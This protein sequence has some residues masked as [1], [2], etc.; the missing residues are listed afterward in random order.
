MTLRSRDRPQSHWTNDLLAKILSK[1]GK[2]HEAV[3]FSAR[4]CERFSNQES[5]ALHSL[6]LLKSGNETEALSLA[7][8]AASMHE[9]SF[10]VSNLAAYWTLVGEPAKAL[11]L[12]RQAVELGLTD[13]SLQNNPDFLPLQDEPEFLA[14]VAEMEKRIQSKTDPD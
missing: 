11:P 1:S 9:N 6:I 14:I 3:S 2:H 13:A 8:E 7:K 4:N 12:L 10:G 5:C